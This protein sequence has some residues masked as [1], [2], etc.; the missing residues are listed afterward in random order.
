MPTRP[1]L[2]DL[3][4]RR[5][6]ALHRTMPT[7]AREVKGDGLIEYRMYAPH[8]AGGALFV[9]DQFAPGTPRADVA[10]RLR[11]LR[12][13]IWGRDKQVTP[14]EAARKREARADRIALNRE[15]VNADT[16]ETAQPHTEPA[17]AP[18]ATTELPATLA[19]TVGEAEFQ[20]QQPDSMP[21]PQTETA[22]TA[23]DLTIE[24]SPTIEDLVQASSHDDVDPACSPAEATQ[25]D[26]EPGQYAQQSL[27]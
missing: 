22:A 16:A 6:P 20:E 18:V 8:P 10:A 7:W 19:Q 27:F 5:A 3:P 2:A 9:T 1:A 12:L 26:S 23:A 17:H 24:A 4:N 15:A 25:A 13:V 11:A 14:E 21:R